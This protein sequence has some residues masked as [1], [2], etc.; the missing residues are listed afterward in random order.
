VNPV[1]PEECSALLALFLAGLGVYGVLAQ[2]IGGR[3]REIGTRVALGARPRDILRMVLGEGLGLVA[4]GIALGL[5]T[6]VGL[7]RLM[8]KLLYGVS[9]ADPLTFAAVVPT[10]TGV[11]LLACLVPARRAV[12]TDP[13]RALRCE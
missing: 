13:I 10:L 2:S 5:A 8:T 7:A 6:A 12:G 4:V 3:T 11:A 9:P 1:I